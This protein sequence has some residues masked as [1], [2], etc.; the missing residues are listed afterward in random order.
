VEVGA[1]LERLDDRAL[2]GLVAGADDLGTGIGGSVGRLD[3][4][5]VP[6]F[7]K[8]LPLADAEREPTTANVFGIP[9]ACHYGVGGP[10]FGAWRELEA[11]LMTTGRSEAFPLLYHAR[12]PPGAPAP[13]AELAD[14]E[15]MVA[16]WDGSAAVRD[17]LHALASAR[18]SLVLF[19]EYVPHGL[20]PWLDEQRSEALV[21]AVAM[22]E[23]CLLTAVPA[24][25]ALG[26]LHF[27]AHFGNLRTDGHRV[28]FTDFGL[29][30]SPA[31]ELSPDERELVAANGGHDLAHVLTE[32]V[33]WLVRHVVGT[34]DTVSRNE[35][36][37]RCAE[38]IAPVGIPTPIAA[39]IMRYAQV[40]AVMNDFYWD[41]FGV[42]RATP[43]PA[44]AIDRLLR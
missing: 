11:H 41:M 10:G 17:R 13:N 33:N 40:A 21:E 7:V 14:V 32:L 16:F 37:R 1:A 22:V 34:S 2:A 38:G 44:A 31:F 18:S 5:G 6:V 30:A 23:R 8:R 29:A 28:V 43:F 9:A 3:V 15:R 12:V 27:D 26:L 24:M 19:L 25:K 20:R 36:V 4:V 35:F 42:S 39:T